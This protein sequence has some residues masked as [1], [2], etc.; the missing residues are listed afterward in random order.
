MARRLVIERLSEGSVPPVEE[1]ETRQVDAPSLSDIRLVFGVG[2]GPDGVPDER[3]FKPVYTV[4]IPVFSLGG[5]DSDGVYEFDAK[6]LL[7]TLQERAKRR[8]WG[9]RLELELAQAAEAI[10][11]ADIYVETPLADDGPTVSLG[12]RSSRGTATQGGGRSL[13]VATSIVQGD[14]GVESLGGAY[15]IRLRDADPNEGGTATV[16]SS[17]R[18]VKLNFTQYEFEG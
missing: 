18:E 12:G 9:V 8:R 15:S 17:A 11:A 13:C 7:S 3:S 2:K 14:A 16:E 5:L 1:G 10:N 6:A 4:S